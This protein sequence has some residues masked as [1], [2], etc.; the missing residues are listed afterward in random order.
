MTDSPSQHKSKLPAA[1]SLITPPPVGAA[2]VQPA[3]PLQAHLQV[4]RTL[5]N[6]KR[7]KHSTKQSQMRTKTISKSALHLMAD[8]ELESPL[9]Q[10]DSR[11]L[12]QRGRPFD[13]PSGAG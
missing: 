8:Q 13:V 11:S 1:G 7:M 5:S 4:Q 6:R 9:V 3:W 2:L 10:A 12:V